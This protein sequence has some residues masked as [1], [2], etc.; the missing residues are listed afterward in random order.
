MTF[1]S[2]PNYSDHL[3]EWLKRGRNWHIEY[4]DYLSNHITHNWIALDAAGASQEKMQWWQDT[5]T[6][7]A[8]NDT[9][10]SAAKKPGMLES[11]RSNP[12]DYTEITNA[13][14]LNNLQSIRIAF[15]LY[16]NFF[17]K[18]IAELG[19][20]AC[21][22]RYYPAL[23]EGMAGAAFHPVIHTG[24][25]VDVDS[26]DMA[27]EGLA[28]MATA[29]QPL[30]TGSI[31]TEHQLWSPDAPRPI[32]ALEQ[33]L[34]DVRI[35][36]LT[37]EADWLSKTEDYKR[38]NRGG[39]QQRLITFDNPEE[40]MSL[41]LNEMVRLKLPDIGQDL[42]SSIE[43][44]TVIAA[45]ALHSSDNEFFILHGLTSLYAVL[46]V[47]P[48][49]DESA[50]RNAL[51]Y[52]FRVLMATI[53][54]QGSPGMTDAV[55]LLKKWLVDKE[56]SKT[57]GYQ[58][59][60]EKKAWWLQTLQSTIDSLDEHVPKAVYVLKRWAEWQSFSKSSHEVYVKAARNITKPN[61]NGELQDN[62]WFS[63]TFTK[64]SESKNKK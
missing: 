18:K 8:T 53:I 60:E 35:S 12:I 6:H 50:Q 48:H 38:L 10:Q 26:D 45:T 5:Y 29:F 25:A 34:N 62:L 44:L 3:H 63:N 17:D 39:F 43:E 47:L 40:S 19:L 32:E 30:A 28:Y 57:I 24:W 54:I 33:I 11:P 49:L 52:W 46:C 4:G 9:S 23:S 21:L 15:P 7:N 14:W 36:Q 31:H 61:V 56:E 1:Y 55:T 13:N 42:T 22:K 51:G 41:F 37:E 16:R 27:A 59:N 58:L 20:S 64:A 2:K